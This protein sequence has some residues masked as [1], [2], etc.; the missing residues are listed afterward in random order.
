MNTRA[1]IREY[2]A[3]HLPDEIESTILEID[4]FSQTEVF[5]F[6]NSFSHFQM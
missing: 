1:L 4:E 2:G 3:D 6:F 5:F